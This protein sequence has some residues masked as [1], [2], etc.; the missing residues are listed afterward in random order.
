MMWQRAFMS[1]KTKSEA[2]LEA[3]LV[4]HGLQFGKIQG[5]ATPRQVEALAV[6]VACSQ[7][8]LAVTLADG[9]VIS[10]PLAWFPRLANASARQ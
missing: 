1:V 8:A 7:D 3:R 4:T 2:V 9:R 5:E 6:E 10:V